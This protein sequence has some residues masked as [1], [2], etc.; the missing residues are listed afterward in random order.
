L[1]FETVRVEPLT[2][3]LDR[4][5]HPFSRLANFGADDRR[6][7]CAFLS[8]GSAELHVISQNRWVRPFGHLSS[9]DPC[10]VFTAER[11]LVER[12]PGRARALTL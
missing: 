8:I 3:L 9:L 4:V 5:A 1:L 6:L 2:D 7:G 11:A 12:T 10:D